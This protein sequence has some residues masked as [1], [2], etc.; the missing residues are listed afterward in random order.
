VFLPTGALPTAAKLSAMS[1]EAG[2]RPHSTPARRKESDLL[3]TL[4]QIVAFFAG[5]TAFVYVAGGTVL[6]IRLFRSD[7]PADSVVTS[8]PRELVISIGLKDVVLPASALAII[9]WVG[10]MAVTHATSI[11]RGSMRT[12]GLLALVLGLVAVASVGMLW[13]MP[14]TK[15]ALGYFVAGL[16]VYFAGLF[17]G[18]F[19]KTRGR[20]NPEMPHLTARQAVV[21]AAV[22]ALLGS[23]VRIVVE[24]ANPR[25]DDAVVCVNDKKP[26]YVGL[27]VG[28]AQDAIYLGDQEEQA[29][30][31]IPKSRLDEIWIGST[32]HRCP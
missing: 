21:V 1:F 32:T 30:I 2:M 3:V 14:S 12:H 27:L 20:K 6:W 16:I 17:A 24:V 31:G 8:L 28:Q 13:F 5:L 7:L 25:L 4:S 29:V 18:W 11:G 15:W 22:I 10:L 19:R 9:A 26:R 23:F